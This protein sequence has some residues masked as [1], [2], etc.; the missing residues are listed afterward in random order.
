MAKFRKE[1]LFLSV[2]LIVALFIFWLPDSNFQEITRI[3]LCPTMA[4]AHR[5]Y[6]K[7]TVV[8][9]HTVRRNEKKDIWQKSFSHLQ[10]KLR[11]HFTFS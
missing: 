4:F 2:L 11:V 9:I 6:A 5:S 3:V 8:K 10:E 1:I 7:Y